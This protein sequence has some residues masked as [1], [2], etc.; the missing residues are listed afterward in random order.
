MTPLI[1]LAVVIFVIFKITQGLGTNSPTRESEPVKSQ[2]F[3]PNNYQTRQTMMSS[4]ERVFFETLRRAV[5]D[6]LD[7]YPQVNL[8]KIFKTKYQSNRFAYNGARWAI[9]RRS[10]DYL[11]VKKDTQSPIAAIE[12]DGSSHEIPDRILRDE[13]VASI[14]DANGVPLIRFNTGEKFS[15]AELRG[16]FERFF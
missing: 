1:I 11:L 7:I 13:K 2:G 10:V 15:D 4:S 9:D 16:K 6:K 3:N 14:F 5:G 8:D 12:L